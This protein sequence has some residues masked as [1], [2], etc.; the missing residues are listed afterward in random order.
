MTKKFIMSLC[1]VALAAFLTVACGVA[2]ADELYVT[3][4]GETIILTSAGGAARYESPD[5]RAV[6]IK[7]GKTASLS[8]DG[9]EISRYVVTNLDESGD[10]M[11]MTVDG[12][13]YRMVSAISAS[14]AKYAA[15]DDPNTVF[16][17]K[18]PFVTL[19]IG[20]KPYSD[21]KVWL[22]SGGI[23]LAG[24]KITPGVTWR[25][26]SI[27]GSEVSDGEDATLT[28]G[29]DGRVYGVAFVNNY[30]AQWMEVGNRLIIAMPISTRKMGP[31]PLMALEKALLSEL[32]NVVAFRRFRD[33]LG[34]VTKDGGEIKLTR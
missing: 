13:N 11:M 18:G 10:V 22:P 9:K 15:E 32:P 16:W 8:I 26:Q 1:G 25:V 5:A 3:L 29:A 27:N 7:N 12:V 23:W 28:F 24:E 21:Y 33:G 30:S 6:F 31:E 14:G 19:T 17:S 20:G 34:L 2:S 4:G